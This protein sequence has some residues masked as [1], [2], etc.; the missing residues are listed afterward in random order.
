MNE[1]VKLKLPIKLPGH[2]FEWV[3]SLKCIRKNWQQLLHALISAISFRL[4]NE[5]AYRFITRYRKV[6]T[7]A[8]WTSR[9]LANLAPN[10]DSVTRNRTQTVT[11]HANQT[12]FSF[13]FVILCVV[14]A[15]VLL[16]LEACHTFLRA[17]KRFHFF[18]ARK[19]EKV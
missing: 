17:Y 1:D 19:N 14:W 12:I 16:L 10:D 3:R 5:D 4:Y 18:P 15:K 8:C 7:R 6:S 2:K 13:F 9:T 11:M